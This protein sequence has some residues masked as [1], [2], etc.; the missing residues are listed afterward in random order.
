M[1]NFPWNPTTRTGFDGMVAKIPVF[2]QPIAKTKVAAKAEHLAR[3]AG[4]GEVTEKDM[5]DAFF[6]ETPFGFHGPMKTDMKD[7]GINYTQYG[8]TP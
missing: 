6:M 8:H 7:L 1:D 3:A 5:V 4:R 2:L